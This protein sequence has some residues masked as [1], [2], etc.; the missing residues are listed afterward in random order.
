MR[1]LDRAGE[2]PGALRRA[3]A[4]RR[5]H[6]PRVL[7]DAFTKLLEVL[8]AS[9]ARPTVEFDFVARRRGLEFIEEVRGLGP[10]CESQAEETGPLSH[11]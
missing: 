9:P 1:Y 2:A 3:L 10:P 11:K 5:G 6:T 4:K 7:S 8:E